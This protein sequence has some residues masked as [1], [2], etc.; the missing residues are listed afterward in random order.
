[1]CFFSAPVINGLR[2]V[3]I[4]IS[5]GGFML[6]RFGVRSLKKVKNIIGG[7]RRKKSNNTWIF[8]EIY[9]WKYV[10]TY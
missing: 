2:I 9:V 6:D 7:E 8:G 4:C 5:S 10:C 1:M 3:N